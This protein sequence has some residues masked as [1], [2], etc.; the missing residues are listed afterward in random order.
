M[1]L[2]EQVAIYSE[3]GIHLEIGAKQGAIPEPHLHHD[4]YQI[5]VLL[6]GE[7]DNLYEATPKIIPGYINVFNPGQLHLTEYHS[8][9]SFIFNIKLSVIKS[10]L[11]TMNLQ[12]YEPCYDTSRLSRFSIPTAILAQEIQLLQQAH[13]YALQDNTLLMYKEDKVLSLLRL[14]LRN[15]ADNGSNKDLVINPHNFIKISKAKEWL[16]QYYQREDITITELAGICHLSPFH[17]IRSFKAAYG[18]SPYDY[19]IEIRINHALNII[20]S[21]KFKNI[22]EVSFTVG[23]RNTAQLRYHFKQLKGCLPSQI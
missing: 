7:A 14:V 17:F 10:L 3:N 5:E 6:K 1:K 11:E 12:P 8:T 2:D 4:D 23:F 21:R 18:K 22:D 15:L 20:K 19:L 16:L 9:D 13:I